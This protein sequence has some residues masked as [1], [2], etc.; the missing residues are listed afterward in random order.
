[1]RRVGLV[2]IGQSPR[3]DVVSEIRD[4]LGDEIEILECGALDDLTR[5]QI[6]QLAPRGDEEFYVTRLRDGSEVRLAV[7]KIIPLVQGC[8]SKLETYVDVIGLLCTG[9][10]PAFTSM[11]PIVEPSSVLINVVRS[12]NPRKLGIVI[13]SPGQR[14]MAYRKWGAI[15]RDIEI[16]SV[17]PYTGKEE[18]LAESAKSLM[19]RD[20]IV[21]DC[22][23]YNRR[24]KKIVAEIT[25]RPTILPRTI[26]ARILRELVEV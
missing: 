23:G 5:E 8:I 19:D 21:L 6:S 3:V 7:G 12:L 18:E 2:T 1:M 22:I 11:K 4:I 24:A 15:T 9:E 25:N 13:P 10:F 14:D 16:V 20:I 26:L 17:S